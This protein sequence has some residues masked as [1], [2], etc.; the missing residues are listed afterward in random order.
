[1]EI[2]YK[3]VIRNMQGEEIHYS[4]YMFD[5]VIQAQQFGNQRLMRWRELGKI[6]ITVDV[7]PNI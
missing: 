7:L 3:F 2:K 4:P 5:T 6:A 1:M